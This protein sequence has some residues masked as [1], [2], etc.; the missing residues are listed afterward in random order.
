MSKAWEEFSDIR[1]TTI[2]IRPERIKPAPDFFPL[3][4]LST[5]K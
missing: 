1:T 2:I 3:T 5:R 4:L